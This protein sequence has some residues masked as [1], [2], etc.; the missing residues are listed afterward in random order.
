MQIW[1][2]AALTG[3]F[4]IAAAGSSVTSAVHAQK[5]VRAPYARAFEF[6]GGGTQIGV[7]VKDIESDDTK[8]PSSGVIVDEVEADSPAEKAG[9][10]AG[11]AIVEFDGERVR[12]VTQFRRLVRET[13]AGRK[14]GAVLSRN[15]QRVTVSVTPE[16]SSGVLPGDD[17]D[18][19]RWDDGARSWAYRV[20]SPPPPPRAPK[21]PAL[22]IPAVPDFDFGMFGRG[23]RLGVSVESLTPQLE[24]FFGVKD[25]VLVRSVSEGSAAAK[26]GLRAGDVITAVNGSQVTGVS[27]VTRAMNRLDDG[28]EFSLEIVRDKKAQTLKGKMESRPERARRRTT[29]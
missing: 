2:S 28:D 16:R 23:G 11:D 17:F 5:R 15:G 21:P 19:E 22:A 20:P 26:A 10:K 1:K 29:V 7:T 6:I 9:F 13:P 25:G 24:E 14:V 8:Q 4:V 12:S 3:A 18:F 27:D